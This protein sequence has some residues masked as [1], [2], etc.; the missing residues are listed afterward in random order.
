MLGSRDLEGFE[1]LPGHPN[2]AT[3]KSEC[4][5]ANG[6]RKANTMSSR[7][8]PNS[9]SLLAIPTSVPSCCIQILS[10][11]DIDM[12]ETT[13]LTVLFMPAYVDD[14]IVIMLSVKECY[15]LLPEQLNKDTDPFQPL[16]GHV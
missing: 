1:N 8:T 3:A 6:E 12:N 15:K 9:T 2:Y 7:G 13:I 10:F 14:L 11:L 5:R 4:C 16:I